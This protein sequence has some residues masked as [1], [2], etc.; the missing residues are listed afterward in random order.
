MYFQIVLAG[1]LFEI[2]NFILFKSLFWIKSRRDVKSNIHLLTET[3]L[4][5]NFICVIHNYTPVS[6][7]FIQCHTDVQCMYLEEQADLDF[8]HS[9][10]GS[11]YCGSRNLH[12]SIHSFHHCTF[13]RTC[14]QSVACWSSARRK[15]DKRTTWCFCRGM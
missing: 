4:R 12:V 10:K 7:F 15:S 3:S 9:K 8:I 6:Y 11:N 13:L 2:I 14:C 5:C 1:V